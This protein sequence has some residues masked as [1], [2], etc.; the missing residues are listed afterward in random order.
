MIGQF[1]I[2]EGADGSG[3]TTLAER[4]V[5]T[6]GMEYQH[7]GP[8]RERMTPFAEHLEYALMSN[9]YNG[10]VFDRFHFG[11]FAYGP[12]FRPKKDVEGIGDFYRAEWDL[13]EE[14][15]R[16]HCLMVLCDPGWDEIEKNVTAKNGGGPYPEYEKDLKKLHEVHRRFRLAYDYTTLPRVVYDYTEDADAWIELTDKI[17]EVLGWSSPLT[18]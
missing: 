11:C 5:E 4:L 15:I 9:D 18:V 2:L 1:V 3:K 13:L 6:Y 17:E 16:P 14:I 12:I 10:I 8:P 7:V